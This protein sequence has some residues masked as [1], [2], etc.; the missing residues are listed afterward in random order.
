MG[1]SYSLRI[2][3]ALQFELDGAKLSSDASNSHKKIALPTSQPCRYG[4]RGWQRLIFRD[5]LCAEFDGFSGA[6][7][8]LSQCKTG[9]TNAF[10]KR[11]VVRR[12]RERQSPDWRAK[13]AIQENGVPGLRR[14]HYFAVVY[15]S[16]CKVMK[17]ICAMRLFQAAK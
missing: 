14:S 10:A 17:T 9:R 6:A 1:I 11:R 8:R 2:R 16:R 4:W 13:N 5:A 12:V 3:H 15:L 7:S